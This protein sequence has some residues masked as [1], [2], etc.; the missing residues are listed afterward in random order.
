MG[1]LLGCRQPF[2]ILAAA[3]LF[4]G[5]EALQSLPVGVPLQFPI[6]LP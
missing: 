5:A 4:G 3:L 2:G 6:M 1:I